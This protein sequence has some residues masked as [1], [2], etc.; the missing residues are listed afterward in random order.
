MT[1]PGGFAGRGKARKQRWGTGGA[2]GLYQRR[3]SKH[4]WYSTNGGGIG[5]KLLPRNGCRIPRGH[6][7]NG[8]PI[9]PCSH[10]PSGDFLGHSPSFG[11]A[12]PS[13]RLWFHP[14]DTGTAFSADPV[15]RALAAAGL[16]PAPLNGDGEECAGGVRFR[17]VSDALCDWVREA[18]RSGAVR[19]LGV[20]ASGAALAGRA[21]WRLLEAGASDV[22]AED[23]AGAGL[24]DEVRARFER[25]AEVDRLV[26]SPLVQNHLVGRSPAWRGLLRQVVEVAA[27]T[28]APVLVTGE[29]GA[30]KELVARL[31][32]SLDRRQGKRELVVLDCAT[33]VAEL[34]GSEFFG[35]ERGAYTGAVGPRDGAFALADRGTLFLDEVGELRPQLQAQLLRAVQERTYKRVGGNT[36]LTTSF[37]LV[38][39]TN[40]DLADEVGRGTFRADLYYR[41]AAVTCR[42]PPLRDRPEDVIPLFLHFLRQQRGDGEPP[43]LDD[44]VREL[45]LRR[46]YPGNVRDLRQLAAR[47]AYRHV[48]PGP[49]TL[50]DLPEDERP[51]GGEHGGWEDD[52]FETSIRRALAQGVGLKEIGRLASETAIR[53]VVADE[54]GNLQRAAQ[55]LGV[56]DRALQL[57][58]AQVRNGRDA[59]AE[60]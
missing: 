11:A 52:A 55:R 1:L 23:R 47:V 13:L 19:V 32:H 14:F 24:A 2:H 20:A 41:L 8:T 10:S 18:G 38:C 22:L 16:T 4:D 33:I 9:V 34:S 7:R 57:R 40:R 53:L 49:I 15:A 60:P 58:K 6:L 5:A 36:W 56:T 45:L 44:A 37:R 30:G 42:M 27:F 59:R 46:A 31:V 28:D 50:G 29:S 21:G 43:E 25:W 35:H 48:G 39:A 12:L 26:E 3:P 54:A 51:R 17:E